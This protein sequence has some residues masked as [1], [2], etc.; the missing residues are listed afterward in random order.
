MRPK[1]GYI[2]LF[3][4]LFTREQLIRLIDL[5][6]EKL[7]RQTLAQLFTEITPD[8]KMDSILSDTASS[9][10]RKEIMSK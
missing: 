5:S 8:E 10:Q 7:D 6:L 9:K 4:N 1:K 3:N 2:K